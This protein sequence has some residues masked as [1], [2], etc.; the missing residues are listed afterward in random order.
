[1]EVV[2]RHIVHEGITTFG[3]PELKGTIRVASLCSGSEMLSVT[4]D[5]LSQGLKEQQ[6]RVNFLTV[7]VCELD[8]KKRLRAES[9]STVSMSMH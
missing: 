2:A 7:M 4:L 3:R 6:V 1:M 8:P 5:A 9:L